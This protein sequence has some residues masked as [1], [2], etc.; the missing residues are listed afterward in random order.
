M[1]TPTLGYLFPLPF[2]FY[3]SIPSSRRRV[4]T[5]FIVGL[6]TRFLPRA[7]YY[8]ECTKSA[9]DGDRCLRKSKLQAK[10]KDLASTWAIV[11]FQSWCTWLKMAIT[12]HFISVTQE[13]DEEM[14]QHISP[15]IFTKALNGEQCAP[16][17]ADTI[18]VYGSTELVESLGNEWFPYLRSQQLIFLLCL[19]RYIILVSLK[20][21]NGSKLIYWAGNVLSV[22]PKNKSEEIW[23]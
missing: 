6:P 13:Q 3:H 7:V 15:V 12:F 21:I 17:S 9:E 4:R 16:P 23:Y 22:F 10:E 18:T 14:Y 11:H 19:W 5:P 8:R 20:C 2:L 1:Y